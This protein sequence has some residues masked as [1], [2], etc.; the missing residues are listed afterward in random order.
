MSLGLTVDIKGDTGNLDSALDATKGKLGGFAGAL[1]SV[2]IP[3]VAAAGAVAGAAVAIADLTMAAAAD[4]DEQAKLEA[5]ITAAGAA[6][7]TSTQ[8]VEDAISAGQDRAFSDSE[9]RAGLE[10]LVSATGDVTKSTELL[11]LSQDVA[12][13]AGV[14][15]EDASKAVAK[16]NAGQT[17]SLQK[18]IPGLAKGAT[19]ADTLANASRLAAGQADRFANSA[20]GM[21]IRGKDA[22]G[23]I[24]ETIGSAFLPVLDEVLPALLPVVKQL[25]TLVSTILPLIIPLIKVL[26]I[27]LGAVAKVLS[28][29]VGW[30]VKL[31]QWLT[32]AA[33]KVGAL[34]DKLNPLKGFKMPS[35]PF[36]NAAPAG[37]GGFG[38]TARGAP[39]SGGGATGGVTVNVYGAI[40][41]E[42]TA[43][44][45]RR[46]LSGHAIRT[47]AG[48]GVGI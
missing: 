24:G 21:G 32:T 17:G 13:K 20:E 19:S 23:E 1:G 4:R 5:A 29:V 8:Q 16:A 33:G 22:F 44:Q 26:A 9:T 48:S 7:A 43:R 42:A 3:A 47:G 34:L 36:L 18:L 2:P 31:V 40:D 6:T 38:P 37:A 30:L 11:A 39:R 35:L 46:I 15:L 25:A 41:P 10:V 12:R 27:A 28:T 14:S 45:I